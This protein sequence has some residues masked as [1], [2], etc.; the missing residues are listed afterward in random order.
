MTKAEK[1]VE[2]NVGGYLFDLKKGSS[3]HVYDGGKLVYRTNI[4]INQKVNEI[5]CN[6]YVDES[7]RKVYAVLFKE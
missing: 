3:L 4:E 7:G 6:S 2:K 5:T 1:L